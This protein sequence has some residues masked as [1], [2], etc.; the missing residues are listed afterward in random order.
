MIMSLL[1]AYN[2]A[3]LIGFGSVLYT[4]CGKFEK[5]AQ[6]YT[7]PASNSTDVHS[8]NNSEMDSSLTPKWTPRNTVEMQVLNPTIIEQFKVNFRK[9]GMQTEKNFDEK[10]L[11]ELINHRIN[12]Y[13]FFEENQETFTFDKMLA[14][15]TTLK[16]F[17]TEL[18][19]Y[20]NLSN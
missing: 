3:K 5:L 9:C 12:Y 16:N 20:S 7:I 15:E 6:D 13:S 17:H 8:N 2:C 4:G 10:V 18:Q 11:V 14:N 1:L 19:S